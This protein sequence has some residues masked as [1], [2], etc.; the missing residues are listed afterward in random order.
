MCFEFLI[1]YEA[2]S[3]RMIVYEIMFEGWWGR[4]EWPDL[5]K[6]RN[7]NSSSMTN[8]RAQ[9][10]KKAW[11]PRQGCSIVRDFRFG[12]YPDDQLGCCGFDSFL[13]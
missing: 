2:A 10:G 9:F 12:G 8:F 4:W 3:P 13:T 7:I 6:P 5:G 11:H 1:G